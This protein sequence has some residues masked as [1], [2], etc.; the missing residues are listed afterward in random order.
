[1][2]VM[3]SFS[4]SVSSTNCHGYKS[5]L[6]SG[7]RRQAGKRGGE[8]LHRGVDGENVATD[9]L[10]RRRSRPHREGESPSSLEEIVTSEESEENDEVLSDDSEPMATDNEISSEEEEPSEKTEE[11]ASSPEELE[12]VTE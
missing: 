1:M 5:R 3:K 12:E 8:V 11:D 10:N 2:I 4:V 7:R 6:K 9:L